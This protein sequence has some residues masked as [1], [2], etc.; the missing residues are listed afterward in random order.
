MNTAPIQ[1]WLNRLAEGLYN[2]ETPDGYP[3]TSSSWNGPGQ[4]ALR[5]EIAKQI[6]SGSAGLFKPD[7]P[8]AT[9]ATRLSAIAE[10]AL[11]LGLAPDPG[12]GNEGRP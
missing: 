8:G 5:F 4:L 10:R 1:G 9:D 12:P 2:H 7:R 6:G 11:F 3:L